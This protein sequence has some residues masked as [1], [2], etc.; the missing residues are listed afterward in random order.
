MRQAF[1]IAFLLFGIAFGGAEAADKLI[2]VTP[3][4]SIDTLVSEVILRKAYKRLGIDV[5]INKY[6]AERALK[7]ADRGHV[8]GEV[9]RI[10]GINRVYR[11][12]L[13]VETEINYI[14]ATVFSKT[15]DFKVD[16]WQSLKPYRIGYII[17]IKF[18]ETNTVSM[19]RQ[20][21][22]NYE[23]LA[24]MLDGGRVDIIVSPR[25]NGWYQFKKLKVTGIRELKPAVQRFGLFHYLHKKNAELVPKISAVL[26]AMTASGELAAIRQRVIEVL[27]QQAER[28]EPVCDKDYK[29]FD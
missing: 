15:K 21:V 6:P 19:K 20:A 12:L 4:N 24:L 18:A 10:A 9:Q 7:M 23:R 11:N 17:G 13:P 16:G 29:C 27:L 28:D 5:Q 3:V 2:L 8:D 26:K 25:N 14:E 22:G 1:A